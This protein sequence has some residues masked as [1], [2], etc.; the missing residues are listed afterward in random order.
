MK[1]IAG[2]IKL[3]QLVIESNRILTL[4]VKYVT[5]VTIERSDE[6]SEKLAQRKSLY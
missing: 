2:K 1:N 5:N 6:R 3:I 4:K